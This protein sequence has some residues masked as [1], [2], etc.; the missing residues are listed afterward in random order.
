MSQASV[1]SRRPELH[2]I[3]F[4]DLL[5]RLLIETA[6]DLTREGRQF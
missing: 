4:R 5:Q 3:P 6:G 1:A 2:N